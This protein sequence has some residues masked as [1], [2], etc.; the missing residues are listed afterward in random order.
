[1]KL[2]KKIISIISFFILTISIV[3][4]SGGNYTSIM[5]IQND[6]KYSMKM[7]YSSFKGEKFTSLKLKDGEELNITIDVE[8][9]KGTLKVSVID[10]DNN[11][12]YKIENPQKT[13]SEKISI[14]KD[15]NYKIKVEG[16]HSGSYNIKWNIKSKQ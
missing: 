4:C 1:M 13:V 10:K 8:T 2:S 11:E 14:S 15:G 16:N 12:L 9:K 3:G 7:S 6:T 5:S